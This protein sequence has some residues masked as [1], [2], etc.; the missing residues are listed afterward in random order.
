MHKRFRYQN[1][2]ALRPARQ[3]KPMQNQTGFDGFSEPDFIGEQNPRRQPAGDFGCD[4]E[5]VRN[6]IDAST[7]EATN[8]GFQLTMLM[9]QAGKPQVESLGRIELSSEQALYRFVEADPI[10]QLGLR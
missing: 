1:Q 8:A 3:N 6:Q 4:I 9:L 2:D 7:D 10:T 5:L